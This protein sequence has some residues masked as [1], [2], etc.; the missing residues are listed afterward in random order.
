MLKHRGFPG[1]LT[2][3]DFQFTIRR[4]NPKGVTPITRRER[5]RDRKSVDRQADTAFLKAL[6]EHF[7]GDPFERGNLDAGRLSWLFGREVLPAEDPFD[8]ADYEALL[9]IDLKVAEANFPEIFAQPE[10]AEDDEWGDD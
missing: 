9:R 1:R 6:I 2:G 10:A 5:Y 4:G 8:P 7:G 3:S